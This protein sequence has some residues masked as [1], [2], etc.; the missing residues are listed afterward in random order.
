MREHTTPTIKPSTVVWENLDQFAREQVQGFIQ[1]LLEEEVT[2]L[3][4]RAKS[5][6]RAVPGEEA[7]GPPVYR[8]GHGK[9]RQLTT[10][11]GPI[12]LRR[13]RVRG[14]AERFESQVLPL[15]VRRTGAVEQVLPELY[16]HGLA[17]GDFDL[18]LRGLLGEGAPLSPSTLLRLKASWQ[19]EYDAWNQRSLA[20]LEVV[21]LWVDGIYVKAG[22]EKEK[23]A[24]LVAV[25]ALSDG[26]KVILAVQA[27]H[28]ESIASWSAL[29][30]DLKRRGLNAPQLVI[31]DGH[32]G[33][34]GALAN[35]YPEAGEQRCWNHRILNVLDK[36]PQKQQGPAK[37]W[38]RQI[39]YAPTRQEA[40]Q[41][42]GKFQAWCTQRGFPEAGELLEEDWERL[43][44]YYDYPAAHWVHLRTTNPVESPFASARL[45]TSAAKRLK[46]VENATAMLWKLLLVAEQ[47][48]RKLNA[49]ELLAKV[50]AG[51][52]YVDGRPAR[53][54]AVQQRIAA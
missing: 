8:N 13:P 46:R 40:A 39:M 47:H 14:L 48:F 43:V 53:S 44:A 35:V 21:Y 18:A 31:G 7:A 10:P 50:A 29:L 11:V 17:L 23:A 25:A 52:R 28:R 26:R 27:G 20:D 19:Q 32:L 51:V 45:R 37:V 6:R 42:K 54:G 38:L 1:R 49:P 36:V 24:L 15:F 5:E 33:I 22:L 12:T 41:L 3:L 9:P 2:E 16:L 4:G 30:R 34:W